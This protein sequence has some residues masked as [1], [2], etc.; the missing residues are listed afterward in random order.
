[1]FDVLSDVPLTILYDWRDDGTDPANAEH[2]FGIVHHD[3]HPGADNVYDPKPAYV[4]VQTYFHQLHGYRF[5]QRLQMDSAN[6]FVLTFKNDTAECMVAW[7]TAP[8]PHAVKIPA[9]DG[10]YSVTGYDGN[11]LS[12]V[13]ATDG[14]MTLL[15]DIGP[16]YLKRR[17]S[18]GGN[19]PPD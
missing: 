7:T 14:F 8:A 6:D 13:T 3:Y 12:D 17:E 15:I 16:R 4:A 11:G 19:A 5:Q 18:T 10:V 2:H 9:L 1:M